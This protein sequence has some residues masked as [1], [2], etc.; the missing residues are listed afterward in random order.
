MLQGNHTAIPEAIHSL[1]KYKPLTPP[2]D[3]TF[4]QKIESVRK[5][6]PQGPAPTFIHLPPS[7]HIQSAFPSIMS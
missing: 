7:V 3:S 6:F 4:T 1:D 5:D 2:F